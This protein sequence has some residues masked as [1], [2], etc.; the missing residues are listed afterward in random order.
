MSNLV[1]FVCL[2]LGLISCDKKSS[3]EEDSV[4]V[5]LYKYDS[6]TVNSSDQLSFD[7]NVF[8]LKG[9][10]LYLDAPDHT[11]Q[12]RHKLIINSKV[13]WIKIRDWKE[14]VY[15]LQEQGYDGKYPLL[16]RKD[17][18]FFIG[19]GKLCY[20]FHQTV[21][22][23]C[24]F[25]LADPMYNQ[26]VAEWGY[27]ALR[28][29]GKV[30]VSRDL[31]QWKIVY[32]GKRGISKSLAF[33]KNERG[34]VEL[35]FSEYTPGQERSRHHVMKYNFDTGE[36]KTVFTFHKAD[37][38]KSLF[39][40]H[41]HILEK[42]PYTGDVWLGTGDADGESHVMRSGDGGET[43][44][45]VGTGS[46]KW[47]VLAFIFTPEYIYWNTD[48]YEE[49][50]ITRVNRKDIGNGVVSET[51][52]KRFSVINSACW[53]IIN[54][55]TP[56]GKDMIVMSSNNEGGLYDNYCRTYGIVLEN[57]VPQIYELTRIKARSIYT[58]LFPIEVNAE[59]FP[60][61]FDHETGKYMSYKLVKD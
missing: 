46:Q 42:D 22:E 26:M 17:T 39:A 56:E 44:H 25:E 13:E 48:S 47:R 24:D 5:T 54:M 2:C 8:A 37:E 40:R 38:G 23:C 58:Q 19:N 60:V 27:Y 3:E 61:L 59:G 4:S 34:Q 53:G 30:Y 28:T 41:I 10:Q 29:G 9:D 49:Q 1:V 35:L 12:R 16:W 32:N 6:L 43:F 21:T 11:P 14:G 36:V 15:A 51:A 7:K 50:Y 55:K 57:D 52:L 45:I 33:V 20:S 18:L 31:K